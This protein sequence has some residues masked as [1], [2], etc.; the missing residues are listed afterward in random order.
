[1]PLVRR[2]C[3]TVLLGAVLVIPLTPTVPA[4]VYCYY[5]I[6]G[7]RCYYSHFL[8]PFSQA[9]CS[10]QPLTYCF[11]TDFLK[12]EL[13]DNSLEEAYVIFFSLV[14]SLG[15]FLHGQGSWHSGT[16]STDGQCSIGTRNS[17]LDKIARMEF[18]VKTF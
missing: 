11:Q 4:F 9:F 6:C 2:L 5:A 12:N 7:I 1:M 14:I 13:F 15:Y 10:S 17:R 18:L 16:W 8:S 3:F